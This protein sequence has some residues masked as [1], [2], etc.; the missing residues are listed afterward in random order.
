MVQPP[1]SLFRNEGTPRI[2]SNLVQ[3]DKIRNS[4][5]WKPLA[6]Y[7]KLVVNALLEGGEWIIETTADPIVLIP[8]EWETWIYL[9]AIWVK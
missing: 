8:I 5:I 9:I 7:S 4:I 3:P 2:S 6:K 1:E